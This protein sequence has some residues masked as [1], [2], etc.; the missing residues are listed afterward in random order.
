[1]FCFVLLFA[2]SLL[3][4]SLFAKLDFEVK[5]ERFSGSSWTVG[6]PQTNLAGSKL[7]VFPECMLAEYQRFFGKDSRGALYDLD[8]LVRELP[9][10][11]IGHVYAQLVKQFGILKSK[12]HYEE[13]GHLGVIFL[14][15]NFLSFGAAADHFAAFANIHTYPKF[16]RAQKGIWFYTSEWKGGGSERDLKVLVLGDLEYD[17]HKGFSASRVARS[18]NRSDF[19]AAETVVVLHERNRELVEKRFI[20]F[21]QHNDLWFVFVPD[22]S[23]LP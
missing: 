1:M 23:L 10:E 12:Q 17:H 15:D 19:Q 9:A 16:T 14:P 3:A 8:S 20:P 11:T 6:G 13:H 7:Q 18:F 21:L 5:P 4:T 2:I 22:N